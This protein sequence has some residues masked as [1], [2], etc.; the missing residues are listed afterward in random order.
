MRKRKIISYLLIISMLLV[1]NISNQNLF[2]QNIIAEA[3]DVTNYTI[4]D[5]ISATLSTDGI[6]D[7]KGTGD[8]P[9]STLSNNAE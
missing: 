4:I 7:I 8:L 9:S 2:K 3:A 5:T 6:L 1:T